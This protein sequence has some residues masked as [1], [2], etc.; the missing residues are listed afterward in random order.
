MPENYSFKK[1]LGSVSTCNFKMPDFISH[2][3]SQHS[4]KL[5]GQGAFLSLQKIDCV[6]CAW[7]VF[8]NCG[9]CFLELLHGF[10]IVS[11]KKYRVPE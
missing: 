8:V 2:E 9:V 7:D 11:E 4:E 3:L 5:N 1:P 10:F 6:G